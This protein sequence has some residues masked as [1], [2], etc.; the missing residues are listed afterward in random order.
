MTQE[1]I[2]GK[3]LID[4]DKAC[5][6]L[7]KALNEDFLRERERER[8]DSS[9]KLAKFKL[10]LKLFE[11]KNRKKA[12]LFLEF[13]KN[14]N[15]EIRNIN[16]VRL[17]SNLNKESSLINNVYAESNVNIDSSS[18]ASINKSINLESNQN[19]NNNLES[20][21]SLTNKDSTPSKYTNI[22]DNKNNN[23]ESNINNNTESKLESN[24]DSA[25]TNKESNN[26]SSNKASSI[27]NDFYANYGKR[28]LN[29]HRFWFVGSIV[30]LPFIIKK[31][32]SEIKNDSSVIESKLKELLNL[33]SSIKEKINN[34]KINIENLAFIY[35]NTQKLNNFK[36]YAKTHFL[37]V[38]KNAKL[39]SLDFIEKHF[40]TIFSWINSN[41]FYE[42]YE[43]KAH[44]Y[45]AFLNPDVLN[46]KIEENDTNT[47][48]NLKNN[49]N[50]L[51]SNDNLLKAYKEY[52]K[53]NLTY[54]LISANVAWDLNIPLPRSYEFVHMSN[55]GSAYIAMQQFYKHCEINLMTHWEPYD[56]QVTYEIFYQGLLDTKTYNAIYIDGFNLKVKNNAKL[57]SLIDKYVSVIAVVRDPIARLRPLVNHIQWQGVKMIWHFNLSFDY[58]R[59]FDKIRYYENGVKGVTTKPSVENIKNNACGYGESS[60]AYSLK[61]RINL[62]NNVNEILYFDMEDFNDKNAY[63]SMKKLARKFKFKEPLDNDKD[64]FSGKLNGGDFLGLIPV[65][66][67][68]NKKDL[69]YIFKDKK[70]NLNKK[71]LYNKENINIHISTLQHKKD[72]Q[73]IA[74]N[75][76]L[77]ENEIFNPNLAILLDSAEMLNRLKT[78]EKLFLETKIY[79]KNTISALKERVMIENNKRI[80][81]EQILDYFKNNEEVRDLYENQFS[82]EL[83]HIKQTRPDIINS[84]TYYK[85]FEKICTEMD[86]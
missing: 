35:S 8:E 7:N 78:N 82:Y 1:A 54:E 23:L 79:I 81:Y 58:K 5:A 72:N 71:N 50:N 66:L 33:D 57:L 51:E 3:L 55:F 13:I 22:K 63:E 29:N 26:T 6:N 60:V 41:E 38:L 20:I 37:N 62:L 47:N 45:P 17:E 30:F 61:S 32:R 77:E 34:E 65:T 44:P 21:K 19:S 25:P 39:E 74:N 49:N 84:W 4:Y 18:K 53:E 52:E 85:E 69:K 76:F 46:Y 70:E 28:L 56:K 12:K 16:E 59:V 42:K 73:I 2:L 40:R 75:E 10:E 31:S 86:K 36:P 80:S 68:I 83:E 11:R 64:K 43:V 24:Q 27:I 67:S 9:L 15:N 14:I 48:E